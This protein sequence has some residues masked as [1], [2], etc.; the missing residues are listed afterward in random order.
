M[1]LTAAGFGPLITVDI[2]SIQGPDDPFRYK[3]KNQWLYPE[4]SLSTRVT[5]LGCVV[6]LAPTA[7]APGGLE[8]HVALIAV[9]SLKQ[10]RILCFL[11]T[12][13]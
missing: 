4:I 11:T 3:A 13:S 8:D 5:Y 1:A 2:A 9:F 10:L 12:G 7:W 6:G